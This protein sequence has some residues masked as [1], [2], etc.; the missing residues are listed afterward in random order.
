MRI[1]IVLFTLSFGLPKL[2]SCDTTRRFISNVERVYLCQGQ[3]SVK[4]HSISNCRGLNN[5]ST[6]MKEPMIF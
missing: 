3:E 4:Y 5:C 1:I 6:Q 2:V